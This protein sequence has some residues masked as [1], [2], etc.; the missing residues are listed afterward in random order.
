LAVGN[1]SSAPSNVTFLGDVFADNASGGFA[2]VV[3]YGTGN[4]Y[5]YDTFR[6]SEVSTPPVGPD[7][8]YEYGI[9]QYGNGF[10]VDHS[11]F[12]GFQDAI[13]IC[14]S[15]KS[16]PVIIK[17]SW[18]HD[19]ALDSETGHDGPAHTD[20]IL[21]NNNDTISY[22]TINHNTIV[23]L[24][25]TQG[26]ALQGSYDHITVTSNYVSG[27]GYTVDLGREGLTNSAFEDNVYGT[28]IE[29]YYGPLYPFKTD[30]SNTWKGNT[31][32]VAKGTT[33]IAEGNNRL[34]WWP[35]DMTPTVSGNGGIN[36]H[37][38]VGHATDYANRW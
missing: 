6:P 32:K 16:S 21:G 12:W 26:I 37:Q 25:N 35:T 23:S 18:F 34:Y 22:I 31:Y 24:G 17:D 19:A 2:N 10:T 9:D 14:C 28:E 15:T 1:A 38:I 36:R 13:Q 5:S 33:W 29:S 8:S 20:G 11:N 27:F 30:N 3:D 4:K 7:N